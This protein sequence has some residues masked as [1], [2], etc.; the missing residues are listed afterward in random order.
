MFSASVVSSFRMSPFEW[1]EL[2]PCLRGHRDV[3]EN[4][5]TLGNSLWFPVG[6]FMQQG[7]EVMPRALSTRCVSGVW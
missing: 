4:P 5:Y 6:G 2:S 3:L 7:S 1:Y